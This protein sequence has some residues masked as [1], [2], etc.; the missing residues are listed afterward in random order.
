MIAVTPVEAVGHRHDCEKV[1]EERIFVPTFSGDPPQ[2]ATP[3]MGGVILWW[4][5]STH[6]PNGEVFYLWPESDISFAGAEFPDFNIAFYSSGG[7]HIVTHNDAGPVTG[8][9]PVGTDHAIVWMNTG[10]G[11]APNQIAGSEFTYAAVCGDPPGP[12]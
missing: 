2:I 11:V 5:H 9:I 4:I 6:V 7:S 1:V 12:F 8:D 3:D 10:P